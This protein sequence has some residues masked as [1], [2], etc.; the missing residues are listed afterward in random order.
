M[1]PCEF[2]DYRNMFAYFLQ[3]LTVFGN[4][5]R[6]SHQMF[7][8]PGQELPNKYM[9]RGAGRGQQTGGRGADRHVTAAER[10]SQNYIQQQ[11]NRYSQNYEGHYMPKI[12]AFRPLLHEKKIFKCFCYI[13]PYQNMFP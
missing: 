7:L 13:N 9:Y 4:V 2:V 8:A 6:N 12:N 1:P 11:P 3:L 10:H 5:S